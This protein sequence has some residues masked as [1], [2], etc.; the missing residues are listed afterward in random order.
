MCLLN[1]NILFNNS[2]NNLFRDWEAIVQKKE[3]TSIISI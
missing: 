1:N 3:I 2:N